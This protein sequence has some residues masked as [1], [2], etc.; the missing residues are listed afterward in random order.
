MN[1]YEQMIALGYHL[2][3]G[4]LFGFSYSFLSICSI[5]FSTFVKC[6]LNIFF[7]LGMST[8]YYYGLYQINSG[9]AHFYLYLIFGISFYLYYHFFYE[10]MIPVF[11]F[12]K[13]I[14]HPLK[15]KI[16]VTRQKMYVIMKIQRSKGGNHKHEQRKKIKTKENTISS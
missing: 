2:L 4:Q 1:I 3:A 15:K 12:V 9:R 11:L 8:L 13:K 16:H 7:C 6:I 14:F 5:S 10:L